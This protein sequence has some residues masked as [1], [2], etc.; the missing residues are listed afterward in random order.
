[1]NK[2]L[3]GAAR[4]HAWSAVDESGGREYRLTVSAG[5]RRRT[6]RSPSPFYHESPAEI[7]KMAQQWAGVSG[8]LYTTDE[9]YAE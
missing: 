8:E 6:Y 3:A 2:R 5:G 9:A 7:A 1:V 4:V